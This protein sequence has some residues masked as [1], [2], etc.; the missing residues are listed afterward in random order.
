MDAAVQTHLMCMTACMTIVGSHDEQCGI[1]LYSTF[2]F[3]SAI[4]LQAFPTS[5]GSYIIIVIANYVLAG[6]R[7]KIACNK[8]FIS[9]DIVTF[10]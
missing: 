2:N 7:Y 8:E 5:Y 1:T 6:V 10:K 4:R 9:G 3:I